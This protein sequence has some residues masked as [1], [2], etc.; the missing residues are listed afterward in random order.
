[1]TSKDWFRNT[2]WSPAIEQ[3][4]HKRLRRARDKSQYLRIQACEL[5]SSHP[6]VA[7]DLL[8]QY[9]AL[10]DSFDYAQ[11]FVDQA[12]AYLALGD[13]DKAIDSYEAALTRE[14]QFPNYIT[15]ARIELPFLIAFKAIDR[16]HDRALEV[17]ELA[18]SLLTFPVDHF[19]WHAAK[20]LIN[21]SC[22]QD[23]DAV[24]SACEALGWAEK[25]KSGFRYHP[26]IG[27]VGREY[28]DVTAR[29]KLLCEN[30]NVINLNECA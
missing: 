6:D 21:S 11:A 8:D 3:E 26:T 2:E 20:A 14:G 4:F 28:D 23:V 19:R 13:L 22:D 15:Q 24:L 9:F 17:L 25:E 27:L 12:T 10:G 16:L 29:L 18:R 1:M 5:T 30:G 7:L